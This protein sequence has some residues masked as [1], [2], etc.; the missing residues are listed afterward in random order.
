ML[1][2]TDVEGAEEVAAI[3][4]QAK[5]NMRYRPGLTRQA[6]MLI[7]LL[8]LNTAEW[9]LCA[10]DLCQ[11]SKMVL[12]KDA[13]FIRGATKVQAYVVYV[14]NAGKQCGMCFKLTQ[15]TIRSLVELH[16]NR[17]LP[18]DHAYTSTSKSTLEFLHLK[19]TLAVNEF[20]FH[21]GFSALK[22]LKPDGSG[23]LA[24]NQEQAAHAAIRSL[25]VPII[26]PQQTGLLSHVQCDGWPTG[27]ETP[28]SFQPFSYIEAF[29]TT[30]PGDTYG[31]MM[32]YDGEFSPDATL[33]YSFGNSHGEPAHYPQLPY[34][35]PVTRTTGN[36]GE[37]NH[38]SYHLTPDYSMTVGGVL[39]VYRDDF[40]AAT[41][42]RFDVGSSYRTS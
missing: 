26:P 10:I 27:Q 38:S 20:W 31:A 13:G 5:Q 24:G 34:P 6:Q 25:F 18:S 7:D 15:E 4:R 28:F 32:N 39:D 41:L 1:V 3:L 35:S 22:S 14:A 40:R 9:T 8:S 36:M 21:T 2:P 16:K 11:V 30:I 29:P 19:F 37:L 23:I 42:Q 17:F 33:Q 12:Q